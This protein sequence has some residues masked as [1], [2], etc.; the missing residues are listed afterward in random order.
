MRRYLIV[1]MLAAGSCMS[2]SVANAA[3]PNI[4]LAL[5]SGSQSGS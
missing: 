5:Q 4:A 3:K 2:A 1:A